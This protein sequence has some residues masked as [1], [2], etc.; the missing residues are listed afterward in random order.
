MGRRPKNYKLENGDINMAEIA[1]AVKNMIVSIS[2]SG[3]SNPMEGTMCIAEIDTLLTEYYMRGY[4]LTGH[5]QF[6]AEASS[7]YVV[8]YVLHKV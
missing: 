8:L 1:V 7:A 3:V 2:K 4:V 5:P 6:I